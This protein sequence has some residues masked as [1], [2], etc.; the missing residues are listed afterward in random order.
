[1]PS[2]PA[3]PNTGPRQVDFSV[4]RRELRAAPLSATLGPARLQLLGCADE[5]L[6]RDRNAATSDALNLYAMS[7]ARK[8]LQIDRVRSENGSTRLGERDADRIDRGASSSMPSQQ[9]GPARERLTEFFDDLA[10]L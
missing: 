2:A 4:Y 3:A 6:S 7:V 5:P 8:R 10:G 1:M 9:G